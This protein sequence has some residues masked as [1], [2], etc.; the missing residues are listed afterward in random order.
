[1]KIGNFRL[2]LGRAAAGVFCAA[3]LGPVAH[4]GT[5]VLVS[6]E[7]D[8]PSS[9]G[10]YSPGAYFHW[11]TVNP[12]DMDYGFHISAGAPTSTA[13]STLTSANIIG[14]FRWKIRWIGAPGEPHPAGRNATIQYKGSATI[15]AEAY[16]YAPTPP[17]SGSSSADSKLTDFFFFGEVLT[18]STTLGSDN[19]ISSSNPT[20]S[21]TLTQGVEFSYVDGTVNTWE[22]WVNDDVN[23]IATTTASGAWGG[24]MHRILVAAGLAN[25]DEDVKIRLTHVDGVR[26]QPD[27]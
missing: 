17:Y 1:M 19:V 21:F 14:G 10:Y 25:I 12:F 8:A 24:P 26:L 22:G 5:Y 20:P 11:D 13:D 18:G 3:F 23:S 15:R 9:P 27:L 4:A 7:W 6:G 2:G 16:L